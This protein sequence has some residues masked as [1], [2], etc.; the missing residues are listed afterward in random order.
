M[1]K[2]RAGRPAGGSE[3]RER[4]LEA[5]ELQLLS[6][7]PS[8]LTSRAIA[9]RAGVSHSLVNY[10]F[11][12]V[13]ALVAEALALTVTPKRVMQWATGEGGSIDVDRLAQGLVRMWEDPVVG[14][15]LV[16]LARTLVAGTGPAPLLGT[17]LERAVFEPLVQHLGPE[18]ARRAAVAIVG[19]I[20]SRYVLALGP[21]ATADPGQVAAELARMMRG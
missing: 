21:T 19:T 5:A 18:R 1:V 11:G 7:D 6:D 3:A 17:Y 13:D 4:L 2:K 10:H 15:R 14:R 12:S 9:L 16:A 8:A 20:F